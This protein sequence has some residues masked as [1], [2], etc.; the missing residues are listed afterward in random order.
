MSTDPD[1]LLQS[2]QT[3]NAHVVQTVTDIL[4]C[5]HRMKAHQ[6]CTPL[7]NLDILG[8]FAIWV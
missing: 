2:Q 5:D 6:N 8:A 4:K 7:L 3:L 1:Q